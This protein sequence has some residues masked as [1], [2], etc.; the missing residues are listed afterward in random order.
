VKPPKASQA[1]VQPWTGDQV[2]DVREYLPARYKALADV[3]S[4]LGLRQGEVFGLAVDDVDFLRRVVHV[5]R[6]VRILGTSMTFAPPK[7]GKERDIPL[8]DSVALLLS[9]H[10]AAHPPAPVTLPWKTSEARPVTARLLFTEPGGAALHRSSFNAVAWQ[11][12]LRGAG[13]PTTRGNG[14]HALRHYFASALLANGVD[15]RAVSE[16]LGH[17][18]PGFTLRT[19]VHLMPSA[20]DRMRQAVDAVF[21]ASDGPAT[22]RRVAR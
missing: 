9:A 17:H 3:G 11:P 8:A 15:I 14:M 6:Q 21:A 13:L 4:G 19:Y 5:H 7:G 16:Y 12:A 20:D 10:I 22:A 1:R 2:A 18:D